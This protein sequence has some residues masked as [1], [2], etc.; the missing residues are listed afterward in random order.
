MNI[1]IIYLNGPTSSGKS[2]LAKALQEALD[3]PFL[4][5]GIDKIIGMMPDKV[6]NWVGCS[7]PLGFSWKE[8]KDNDGNLIQELQMGPFAKQISD[9]YREVVALLVKLG[10]YVIIDDVSFGSEEMARW[11]KLLQNYRVLYVGVKSPLDVLE[12][13]EKQRGNRMIGSAREQYHKVH[14]GNEYD[15]EVDTSK[16]PVKECVD[17]ILKRL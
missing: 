1:Q 8:S 14:L 16:S 9:T 17:L 13:R 3:S 11:R 15:V 6:N 2:T 4:H 7:A 12:L 10:H 5:I